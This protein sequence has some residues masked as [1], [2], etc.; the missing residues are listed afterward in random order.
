MTGSVRDAWGW[1]LRILG[2]PTGLTSRIRW[3]YLIVVLANLTILA[4]AVLFSGRSLLV[5]AT[6]LVA[7]GLLGA[8][9]V[10]V[11]RSNRSPYLAT[12]VDAAAFMTVGLVIGDLANM[13]SLLFAAGMFAALRGRNRDAAARA[14]LYCALI[15]A[16]SIIQ[17]P[18]FHLL[19]PAALPTFVLP[20]ML[21]ALIPLRILA[22][23]LARH[24]RSAARQE[25]LNALSH[26]LLRA[27]TEAEV[28]ALGTEAVPVLLVNLSQ[29]RCALLITDPDAPEAD[30]VRADD[31]APGAVRIALS[32]GDDHVGVLLASADQPIGSGGRL[33][34]EA[35]GNQVAFAIENVRLHAALT[36]RASHDSLTALPNR[37]LLSD[38]IGETIDAGRLVAVLFID[39]DDFKT[40]NDGL[41]HSV[42][43]ALLRAV[44]GRLRACQRPGDLVARLGGDEF[45]MVMHDVSADQVWQ[46][47]DRIVHSIAEP[48]RIDEHD[49]SISCSIGAAIPDGPAESPE[50]LLRDADVAMYVA[51]ARGKNRYELVTPDMLDAVNGGGATRQRLVR[52]LAQDEFVIHYQPIV[53]LRNGAVRGFEA[54]LRWQHP[55][56]GLLSPANFISAAE[57]TGVIVPIETEVL[58]RACREAASWPV[59]LRD[60]PG[61][62]VSVNISGL[63]L[64]EPQV[65]TAVA[66][67][68]RGSGL[69]G[70]RLIV[71]VTESIAAYGDPDVLVHLEA[72]RALGV[73]VALDDF[74]IG[75]SSLGALR[76]L[77]VDI[78]KIDRSFTVDEDPSLA[79]AVVDLA[80]ALGLAT[81]AEGVETAH[82]LEAMTAVGCQDAQGFLFSRALAPADL[83]P[84]LSHPPQL[85]LL[86]ELAARDEERRSVEVRSAS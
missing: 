38:R 66:D 19:T 1:I 77:P 85:A 48:F 4:P 27:R 39:L 3:V 17:H 22:A 68:L 20:G 81:V 21:F 80:A 31:T 14:L 36:H 28:I 15:E 67:A 25:A 63:H 8:G 51:K 46:I 41:G 82:Q 76:G 29:V 64:R 24:E 57:Q 26:R 10:R 23:T 56:R 53:D 62:T 59:A 60:A 69:P 2:R 65:V 18:S 12:A 52:A 70:T 5:I 78:V 35:L 11:Y 61:M 43:D 7:V 55:E 72:I 84:F 47:G 30:A 32:A 33:A 16:L 45:G 79:G 42:G 71:E 37:A 6:G 13:M 74:G 58:R 34:L 75:Y 83:G 40:V 9:Y 86:R 44:A 49:I 54:L 73:R 50:E